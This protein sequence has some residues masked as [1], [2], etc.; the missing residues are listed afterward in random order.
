MERGEREKERERESVCVCVSMYL[1]VCVLVRKGH[2][3][4]QVG[5]GDRGKGFL[6]GWKSLN[7]SLK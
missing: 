6:G 5:F 2:L 3:E 4:T 1:S 7:K